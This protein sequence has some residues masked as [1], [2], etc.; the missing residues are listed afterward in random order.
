MDQLVSTN[1]FI[2]KI[3]LNYSLNICSV[4]WFCF[5]SLEP[6]IRCLLEVP[7]LT[8][9]AGQHWEK[10]IGQQSTQISAQLVS[11]CPS[12]SLSLVS[13]YFPLLS[14]LSPFLSPAFTSL[15][16]FLSP[17][18]CFL[19]LSVSLSFSVYLCFSLSVSVCLCCC[20]SF[21]CPS[22]SCPSFSVS[23]FFS[24]SLPVS[25]FSLSVSLS[26]SQL[27]ILS[28]LCLYCPSSML[29]LYMHR[30]LRYSRVSVVTQVNEQLSF[31]CSAFNLLKVSKILQGQTS[32]QI[33]QYSKV[34]TQWSLERRSVGPLPWNSKEKVNS[35]ALIIY[36]HLS[37]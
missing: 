12:S 33:L 30:N 2:R 7:C 14:F 11:L 15:S 13:L 16:L 23:L 25:L 6:S 4:P 5:S 34:I 32:Y 36:T 10:V 22:F 28:L 17:S 20:L 37:A 29:S 26:P 21:L 1:L 19:L 18:L 31:I 35:L 8:L 3:S 27:L 9:P 24:I